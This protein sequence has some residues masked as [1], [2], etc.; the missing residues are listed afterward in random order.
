MI[1]FVHMPYAAVE[2][3]SLALG[4]LQSECNQRGLASRCLYPNLEWLK[5]LGGTDYHAISS[6][7][8]EDLVGEWTFAEAAFRDQTPRA[9]GYLDF[10]CRRGKLATLPEARAMLLRAREL[11]HA[12]IDELALQVLSH[13]PKVVGASSTFQQH[14]ASLSLLRRIKELDP[15]VVTMMGG[16][17]CEGAMGVTLVRHFPW[18][19]YAVSG[20]ADQLIGPFMASLLEGQPRPPYGVISRDS[21]TWKNGPEGQAPRATFLAMDKVARP[22]YDDYFRALRDS[23][24][25]LLPG[26]LMETSRG[27]WWGEKHHCTFC[28]LNGSGMGYRS[29][30]GERVLEEMEALASRYGLGGFEVVDNILDHSHLKNIMPVLAARPKPFDLFYETK[31][32]LKREQV[33]LLSR[34]GV[35]WIQ[36]GIESMHDDILR[37]MDKGSTALTNV[38]LLQHAREYGVRVIWNFLICFPGEK[39]E[40]YEEMVAWLP[41]IHHLQPAN[42]MAPVRYDRFSPYHSQPERYG[43][44]YQ[45]TRT[46]AG[47]YPLPKQELENLAYF[48]EDHTD[49]EIP[50][51]R[52]H[53]SPGRVALRHALKVWRDQFWSA[54]PPILSMQELEDELLILDTRQV[55]TARRHKLQGRRR[56]LLLECR[57]PRRYAAP[58]DDLNWLVEN[59]LVLELGQRYLSLPVAGNLPS[60]AAPW[61]F[62]GGF[63]SRP[64][65]CPPYR[66]PDF[67]NVRQT[68][69]ASLEPRVQGSGADRTRVRDQRSGAPKV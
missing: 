32:N 7:I 2:H 38:Q 58:E 5:K 50:A 43:I 27:C 60:L 6:A 40:W 35:L 46:Y 56:E 68:A 37:L 47:V 42:G 8:S 1:V 59:K 49:L 26:L 14:C 10:V 25:D 17:N 64:E 54:L 24:L 57:T 53:D 12:F 29:K 39:D 52:R 41:L 19:D 67:L 11:S 69:E 23:G 13:R 65:N 63:P 36:P 51:S 4:I 16:A 66:F 28:G 45:A 21:A 3:P 44:R 20:E 18:I 55:A 48:F 30:S 22:D 9:E 31:S 62:P 34:A 15:G 61:R 33:E